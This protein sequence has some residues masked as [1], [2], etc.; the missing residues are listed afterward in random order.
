ME[1]GDNEKSVKANILKERKL[2]DDLKQIFSRVLEG[3]K[4]R[5]D[6]WGGGAVGSRMRVETF[7]LLIYTKQK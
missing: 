6:S 4:N 5:R 2:C 3:I 1:G 7:S